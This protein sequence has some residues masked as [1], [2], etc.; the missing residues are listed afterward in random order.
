MHGAKAS[1]LDHEDT[2][3]REKAPVARMQEGGRRDQV[4][5]VVVSPGLLCPVSLTPGKEGAAVPSQHGKTA[6]THWQGPERDR[7]RMR[8]RSWVLT[9]T[10]ASLPGWGTKEPRSVLTLGGWMSK[11]TL[12]FI[13]SRKVRTERRREEEGAGESGGGGSRG[14]EEGGEG[15]G[16]RKWDR[17]VNPRAPPG[18]QCVLTAPFL[19]SP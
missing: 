18:G 4:L 10:P 8:C 13:Q 11:S 7:G 3:L 1:I 9:L 5:R 19:A 2:D 16:R 14:G 6:V 15:R 12:K 17:A